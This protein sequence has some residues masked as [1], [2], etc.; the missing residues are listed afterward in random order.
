MEEIINF[1]EW[2]HYI[3]IVLWIVVLFF[4]LKY[5]YKIEKLFKLKDDFK[6]G[7]KVA[8]GLLITSFIFGFII[9]LIWV[10]A[11]EFGQSKT[12]TIVVNSLIVLIFLLNV[13]VCFKNYKIVSALLRFLLISILMLVYFYSAWLSGL[14]LIG[15]FSL[16]VI[17]YTLRWLKITFM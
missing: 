5:F 8:V 11:P 12:A 6:S 9:Y 3:F 13:F 1:S 16:V 4:G 15:V 10:L 2:Y 7:N 14:L 17:F